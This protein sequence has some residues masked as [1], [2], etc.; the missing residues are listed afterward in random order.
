MSMFS[1]KSISNL[2]LYD[3]AVVLKHLH[4]YLP[5]QK[6]LKD[7][8][9][10]NTL[11]SFQEFPFHQ[12]LEKA[13]TLF[14]YQ[15]Y[16][17]L[18]EFRKLFAEGKISELVLIRV[19]QKYKKEEW[20]IWQEKLLYT[21]YNTD[22][23][24][25]LGQLRR[26]WDKK[27]NLNIDK[28]TAGF[29]FRFV[30]A[31]IDQGISIKKFPVTQK[32]FLVAIRELEKH[33]FVKIFR[34][35][36]VRELLFQRELNTKKLL[37]ILVGEERYYEQYLF[38][39]QFLHPGWSGM[40]AVLEKHPDSL[41]DKRKISLK[42]FIIFE[43][44]LEIDILD[45]KIGQ[46]K[47]KNIK[48]F[49]ENDSSIQIEPLFA[50]V[51]HKELFEVYALWQE[52]YEW[53]LYDQVLKG[54]QIVPSQDK[55]TRN[56]QAI[57]C[58]DDRSCSIR[59][60]IEHFGKAETFGTAGFFNFEF[61]F[62]PEHGRF[63][64]KSCPA[65]MHPRYL[66]K[67]LETQKHHH[68]KDRH[69]SPES[70]NLLGGWLVSQTLGFWSA[71]KLAWSIFKPSE[72]PAM[73]SSFRHMDK[74]STLT[75]ECKDEQHH[76]KDNLQI[77]FTIPEMAQRVEELL[78][79][80]GLTENF[81]DLVYL[82]GHGASSVN[83]THYAGYDCGACSGRAGSVNA[84]VA[85]W[86]ANKAEVR[87]ILAQKGIHIPQNTQFI[88]AL[89]DTTRDEIE[90]FDEHLLLPHN[91]E[92]HQKNYQAFQ[93][94]LDYNAKERSRRFILTDS[95]QEAEK[96]HQKVKLRALSLFEPRPEWNHATNA[97]C[98]I[99]RRSSNKHLY[100]DRRSFLNS[101]DYQKDL[102][103]KYLL[104]I[105]NAVA[106]VCGGINL[107]YYFS[108]VDNHRLGAGSKLPHNVIGLIGVTNG[109]EGD[110]RTGL[111]AQ[112]LNIH[113]PVRLLIV[114]EHFPEVVLD[115]IQKNTAT[116][117]WFVGHW[118]HLAVIHPETKKLFYFSNNK[119]EPYEPVTQNLPII[120]NL[121]KVFEK[122]SENLPISL[123]QH[124]VL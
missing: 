40:V 80:I 62:Q 82:V 43:L 30:S 15:T 59:R 44:L 14:G 81:A 108:K 19:L 23:N 1:D 78:R 41:L 73:V 74:H 106:P 64:T 25:R 88:G 54:L 49:L 97:I 8:V 11:H 63:Y 112:M 95:N 24:H 67:E 90:F 32:S 26:I 118:I 111:P 93:K 36:R 56:F 84:R 60:Y 3:E 2:S 5:H 17:P 122:N 107:E 91:Q 52:A 120:E 121:T 86:A 72:T 109:L 119:F 61:Y 124:A 57:F 94:A 76:T 87:S 38:E 21:E 100:L 31:Y 85:A 92:Q 110:L 68:Q 10:H 20:K 89:H 115:V 42:H 35:K 45:Y 28:Q 103:G 113:D 53:T 102:D 77:G 33:S 27:Y 29:L 37:D 6:P 75:I 55:I 4:H 70:K 13:S 18:S 99:G 101:Y 105:L 104:G 46:N 117:N 12:A 116:Y 114:V 39:Q 22:L 69:F 79:S 9:H 16:L 83:N 123:L 65:P 47:W 71:I 7:F 50:P 48:Y 98:L 34:S 51:E 58:I 66:I 96:V